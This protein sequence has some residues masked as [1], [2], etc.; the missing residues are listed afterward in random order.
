MLFRESILKPPCFLL[1]FYNTTQILS[2]S[3]SVWIW[4]E[5]P[6]QSRARVTV[7][8]LRRSHLKT[9][10]I[11]LSLSLFLALSLSL[12]PHCQ[13]VGRSWEVLMEKLLLL[14]PLFTTLMWKAPSMLQLC[15]AMTRPPCHSPLV[16]ELM[17]QPQNRKTDGGKRLVLVRTQKAW[18][19][20]LPV[21]TNLF[22]KCLFK[23]HF[24]HIIKMICF[25]FFYCEFYM[26]D[27]SMNQYQ[28]KNNLQTLWSW[29]P[30]FHFIALIIV[31]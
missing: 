1:C 7:I 12:P 31:L 14:F 11:Q 4:T 26:T 2:H 20:R 15:V 19:L 22:E 23:K 6:A 10:P 3:F 13:D 27:L 30:L 16:T 25:P 9:W 21:S 8:L 29:K 24:M 17:A 28:I 5:R 18:K